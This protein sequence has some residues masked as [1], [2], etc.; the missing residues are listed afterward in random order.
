MLLSGKEKELEI[1]VIDQCVKRNSMGKTLLQSMLVSPSNMNGTVRQNGDKVVP[2][3][4]GAQTLLCPARVGQMFL[5]RDRHLRQLMDRS[6]SHTLCVFIF[7]KIKPLEEPKEWKMCDGKILK[8]RD[9]TSM[10]K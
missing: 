8:I 7:F 2:H 5:F 6:S 9:T 1:F 10:G 3:L 4:T